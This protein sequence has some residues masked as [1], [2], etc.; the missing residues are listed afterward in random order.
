V[1]FVEA[2]FFVFF[3]IVFVVYWLIPSN[4]DRKRWL[5]ATSYVFYGS[6]DYRF[7]L[8]LIASTSVDYF[9]ALYIDRTTEQLR[10]KAVF[11]SAIAFNLLVLG[12]FK[13][14]NFFADSFASL[15]GLF[16]IVPDFFTLNVL[17][18]V[19][20]SFYTFQTMSY[21][22]DVYRRDL[23]ATE[24]ILDFALFVAFFPQL[25]AGPIVRAGVLLKQFDGL[26]QFPVDARNAVLLCVL[27]YFKKA[28]IADNIAIVIDPVWANPLAYDW[29]STII[30]QMLFLVQIY[31]DF[32]GYSDIAVGSAALLGYHMPRNFGPAL[33]SR[34]LSDTWRLWHITLGSWFRDYF[35]RPLLKNRRDPAAIA[36]GLFV[37]MALIGLWHGA[38]WT[39][40]IWGTL[41]G[42][43]LAYLALRRLRNR[44]ANRWKMPYLAALAITFGFDA[45]TI[46][47]FRAA[48]IGGAFSMLATDFLG[49]EGTK[50]LTFYPFLAFAALGLIHWSWHRYDLERRVSAVSVNRFAVGSGLAFGIAFSLAPRDVLPFIYFQF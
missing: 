24:S 42:L 40:V 11:W 33:L 22:I 6:W 45:L 46:V 4:R 16:G 20:I 25:V 30:S 3:A 13:Y 10:R 38:N 15:L 41:Q 23:K 26:R 49:S 28:V 19:G 32:S 47:F 7:L 1:V 8:L 2:R 9:A 34:N 44:S 37:T 43:G 17:L 50:S 14:F 12:F 29:S 5:L 35:F 21:T 27:G 36:G 39:F 31:C 48:D 18:P